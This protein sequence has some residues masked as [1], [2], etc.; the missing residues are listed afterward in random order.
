M[1]SAFLKW[2]TK[3]HGERTEHPF[4]KCSDNALRNVIKQG[5]LAA[6]ELKSRELWDARLQSSLYAWQVKDYQL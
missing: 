6:E 4:K 5:L 1:E 3:Q 2:F